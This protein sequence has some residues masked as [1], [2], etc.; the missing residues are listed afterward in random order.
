MDFSAEIRQ[1]KNNT[2]RTKIKKNRKTQKND[3]K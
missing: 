3:E 2:K 1:E